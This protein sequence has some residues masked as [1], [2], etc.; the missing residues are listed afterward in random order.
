LRVL[1]SWKFINLQKIA[2][3]R[4]RTMQKL[5]QLLIMNLAIWLKGLYLF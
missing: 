4:K 3:L 2:I 1:N 5:I